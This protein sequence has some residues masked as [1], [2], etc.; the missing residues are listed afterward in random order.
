MGKS[1][2]VKLP[3]IKRK[4]FVKSGNSPTRRKF[5]FNGIHSSNLVTRFFPL[6]L[7]YHFQS[8]KSR[9]LKDFSFL[10]RTRGYYFFMC[11]IITIIISI[12]DNFGNFGTI[13]LCNVR[14]NKEKCQKHPLKSY[15]HLC[16]VIH[17][18]NKKVVSY[19]H[20]CTSCPQVIH[21]TG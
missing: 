1:S 4:V 20:L 17:N 15:P 19:P 8:K 18:L 11:I 16:K 21:K 14:I 10:A 12:V 3:A 7:V 6:L 13:F 2:I 5:D 9:A